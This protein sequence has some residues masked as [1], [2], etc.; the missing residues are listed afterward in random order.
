MKKYYGIIS[1]AFAMAAFLLV[2]LIGC[3]ILFVE[4]DSAKAEDT[5]TEEVTASTETEVVTETEEAVTPEINESEVVNT[6]ESTQESPME[7]IGYDEQNGQQIPIYGINPDKMQDPGFNME[8]LE[9]SYDCDDYYDVITEDVVCT[10]DDTTSWGTMLGLLVECGIKKF[11][12]ENGVTGEFYVEGTG[13]TAGG[14]TGYVTAT[15]SDGYKLKAEYQI[16]TRQVR[17]TEVK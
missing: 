4:K 14:E 10:L 1:M 12:V 13:V 15:R 2:A 5:E 17:V 16:R 8:P 6:E 7:I 9:G 11:C 3:Y